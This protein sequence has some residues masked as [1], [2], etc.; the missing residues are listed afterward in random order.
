M[1]DLT[2][3]INFIFFRFSLSNQHPRSSG[4]VNDNEQACEKN[5]ILIIPVVFIVIARW[6]FG[7]VNATVSLEKSRDS[8][9]KIQDTIPRIAESLL[10]T[11][12][13]ININVAHLS[14]SRIH[15]TEKIVF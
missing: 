1:P 11:A 14:V 6:R 7:D 9:F 12:R 10:T 15:Y 3:R 8:M 13:K 5:S 4:R 2:S